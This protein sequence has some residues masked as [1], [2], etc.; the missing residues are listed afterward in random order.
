MQAMGVALNIVTA[1]LMHELELNGVLLEN[2][3]P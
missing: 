3:T 2:S 1:I